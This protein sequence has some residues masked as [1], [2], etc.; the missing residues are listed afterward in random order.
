M[1][2]FRSEEE[3]VGVRRVESRGWRSV[4]EVAINNSLVSVCA[5]IRHARNA[6]WLCKVLACESH[7][8][9]R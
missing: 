2:L 9:Q 5:R 8:V 7:D 4:G 1:V 6:E 3:G